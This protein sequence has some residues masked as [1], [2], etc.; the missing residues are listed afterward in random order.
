MS[1]Q[2][3]RF[4]LRVAAAACLSLMVSGCMMSPLH[5]DSIADRHDD[6]F[7]FRG[8]TD[9]AF[10]TISIQ[11]RD[12]KGVWNT[13]ATTE[14]AKLPETVFGVTAYPWAMLEVRV[15]LSGHY[16]GDTEEPGFHHECELRAVGSMSG[17]LATFDAS[18]RDA[19]FTTDPDYGL[20]DL[21]SDYGHG[22]S[23]TVYSEN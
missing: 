20:L 13:I 1:T 16:W 2:L 10:E 22:D 8:A 5:G 11:A 19:P 15:P 17:P 7:D 23:V 12:D 4:P 6:T 14:S 21:W 9:F 3:T 18:L